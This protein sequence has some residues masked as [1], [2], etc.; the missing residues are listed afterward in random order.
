M[1]IREGDPMASS[2]SG[3]QWRDGGGGGA[4]KPM[5]KGPPPKPNRYGIRPGYRWDGIDRGNG[6]ESR[7]LASIYSKARK[8]EEAYRISCADM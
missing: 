7:V 3:T 2:S 1:E 5:Y 8:K 6:F 4:A